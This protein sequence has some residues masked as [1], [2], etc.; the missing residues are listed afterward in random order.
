MEDLKK[1]IFLVPTLITIMIV[2][3]MLSLYDDL[4][5]KMADELL[6]KQKIYMSMLSKRF[7]R[8]KFKFV[9]TELISLFEIRSLPY[10][11]NFENI[12]Y[13]IVMDN[14][15]CAKYVHFLAYNTDIPQKI[16]HLTL[17]R[18]FDK[19]INNCIPSSVTHLTFGYWFNR[20]IN[21]CIPSSVTH[22]TF[23]YLFS[24]PINNCI[25]PSVTHLTLGDCFNQPINNCIPSSVTH[26]TLGD[27]FNQ[28]I[29]N[30][31][32]S[33]VTH[34]TLVTILINK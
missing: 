17:D 5:I 28:P 21:N 31:I 3:K 20:S 33:S 11:D 27:C 16:T 1:M 22:L 7:D 12:S 18:N 25:P 2:N 15:K 4:I 34:L 29:N 24:Q 6:D 32:P 23:G 8:L 13:D 19:P 14:P 10:F 30:C 26:L 9:Y